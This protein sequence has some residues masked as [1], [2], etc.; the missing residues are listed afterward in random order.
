MD[1]QAISH[2]YQSMDVSTD[3]SS[4]SPVSNQTDSEQNIVKSSDNLDTKMSSS[5]HS[6]TVTKKQDEN[7]NNRS[8]LSPNG[9]SSD[10]PQMKLTPVKHHPLEFLDNDLDDFS[11]FNSSGPTNRNFPDV[12]LMT[13]NQQSTMLCP[14]M[15]SSSSTTINQHT[16]KTTKKS[17]ISNDLVNSVN[18]NDTSSRNIKY[19]YREPSPVSAFCRSLPKIVN[20]LKSKHTVASDCCSGSSTEK[21]LDHVF[22]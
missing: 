18:N 20:S 21:L 11:S 14:K 2:N 10:Q 3:A 6:L 5:F 22:F 9:G 7:D 13:H 19:K 4:I 8:M 17:T 15:T 1:N 12:V 16:A